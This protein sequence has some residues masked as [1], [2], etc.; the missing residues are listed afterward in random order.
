MARILVV[1]DDAGIV[2]LLLDLLQSE[3]HEARGG[4]GEPAWQVAIDW[5][6]DLILLDLM[7]PGLDGFAFNQRLQADPR[8]HAIPVVAMSAAYNLR[9]HGARLTVQGV[10]AKPFDIGDL[11]GWVDR[12]TAIPL[13]SE[14]LPSAH[15]S[16]LLAADANR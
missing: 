1:D 4:F 14:S 11:L 6:P 16:S 13:P 10:L 5:R 2:G 7:M 12:L 3:R 8:T 15:D 9:E